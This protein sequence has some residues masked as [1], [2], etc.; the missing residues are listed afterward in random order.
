[1]RRFYALVG[2]LI[3]LLMGALPAFAAEG[4][5]LAN[6]TLLPGWF[7]LAMVGLALLL[8]IIFALWARR[9]VA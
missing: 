4:D 5:P 7:A 1:M 3:V 9:G 8:I 2:T 6:S